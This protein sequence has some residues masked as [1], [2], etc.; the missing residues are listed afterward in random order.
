MRT[1]LPVLIA[2][3]G[4]ANQTQIAT[5]GRPFEKTFT[6]G[7]ID[8]TI[9]IPEKVT[10]GEIVEVEIAISNKS[11][12]FVLP[13]RIEAA[14]RFVRDMFYQQKGRIETVIADE[15][16]YYDTLA[17]GYTGSVFNETLLYPSAWTTLSIPVK[18]NVSEMP[19]SVTYIRLTGEQAAKR[20]FTP[21]Y[22]EGKIPYRRFN[23]GMFKQYTAGLHVMMPQ[24]IVDM[25][26]LHRLECL[27][28]IPL[29][30]RSPSYEEVAAAAKSL[31][32]VVPDAIDFNQR[33]N[34]WLVH[35]KIL[36]VAYKNG[37]FVRITNM[38]PQTSLTMDMV[39]GRKLEIVFRDET[40]A[41]LNDVVAVEHAVGKNEERIFL[42][43]PTDEEL[44]R[45]LEAG[46]RLGFSLKHVFADR[47]AICK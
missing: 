29:A 26:A 25:Q 39:K 34:C 36:T 12:D 28:K 32:P 7:V 38:T 10:S 11:S 21:S 18:F 5:P 45:L 47:F 15:L 37:V 14:G 3:A 24:P 20:L 33:L 8:A 44:R 27:A 2:I 30:R 43:H 17:A 42:C 13:V 46:G 31:S 9:R 6:D 4:C 16:Y 1:L 22:S 40:Q 19:F 23:A 41:L 35:Y